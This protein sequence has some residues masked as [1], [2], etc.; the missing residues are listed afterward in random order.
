[1]QAERPAELRLEPALGA[2]SAL[3][4]QCSFGGPWHGFAVRGFAS[5]PNTGPSFLVNG[6][7]AGRGPSRAARTRAAMR[8]R[9]VVPA[10]H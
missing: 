3:T 2:A 4:Q 1:V 9:R 6:F 8:A 5:D 10:G 7:A